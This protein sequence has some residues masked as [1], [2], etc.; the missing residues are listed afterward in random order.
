MN[1]LLRVDSLFVAESGARATAKGTF[2]LTNTENG[3]LQFTLA[4]D[5]LQTLRRYIGTTDSHSSKSLQA[6]RARDS[7]PLVLIPRD[8]PKR[9]ASSSWHSACHSAFR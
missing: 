5:S 8:A 7:L 6:D 2:G 3:K 1:G 9:C 4:V